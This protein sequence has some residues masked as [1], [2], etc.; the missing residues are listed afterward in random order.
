MSHH[1]FLEVKPMS[2]KRIYIHVCNNIR[3]LT[4][5]PQQSNISFSHQTLG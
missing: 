1:L 3:D 2:K 5:T 4:S